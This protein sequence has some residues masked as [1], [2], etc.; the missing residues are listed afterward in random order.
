MQMDLY[1]LYFDGACGP[2]N[3]GGTAAYGYTLHLRGHIVDRGNAVIGSGPSFSNNVA[4][5]AGLSAGLRAFMAYYLSRDPRPLARLQVYGDSKLVIYQMSRKWKATG[6]LYMPYFELADGLASEVRR[7]LRVPISFEWIPREMN[8]ECDSL[9]KIGV[10][11]TLPK[12]KTRLS[13]KMT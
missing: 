10:P 1:T 13:V 12:R 9:S 11:P 8:A 7:G 4:E 5:Y 2:K 6:G 3:P